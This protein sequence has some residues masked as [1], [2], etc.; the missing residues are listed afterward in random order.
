VNNELF[1]TAAAPA[2]DLPQKPVV[3]HVGQLIERKGVS[4]LL[5]AAATLQRQGYEFSLLLVGNGRG[6]ELLER[7]AEAL[8]LKNVHF[9][10]AQS[11]E[12]MPA[13]Y[14]SAD[15]LVF[16]TLEDVWGLVANEAILSGLPVLCSKYA[17][18]APEL[19]SPESIFS[20]D[21]PAQFVEKLSASIAG[22]LRLADR[23]LLRPIPELGRELVLALNTVL[24]RDLPTGLSATESSVR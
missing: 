24:A 21:D 18:C 5:D 12:K 16:P 23:A 4:L 10:S 1:L 11:P 17:G 6:K 7:R 3:L 9:K 2:W 20:P 13:V 14:R 8:A 19:F 15:L 22:R